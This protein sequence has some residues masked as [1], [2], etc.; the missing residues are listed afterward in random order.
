MAL[1]KTVEQ[2]KPGVRVALGQE[3]PVLFCF[4]LFSIFFFLFAFRKETAEQCCLNN[5]L[6]SSLCSLAYLL[7]ISEDE[8]GVAE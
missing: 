4:V 3:R 7:R 6:P 1:L 5:Y 2:N 8:R